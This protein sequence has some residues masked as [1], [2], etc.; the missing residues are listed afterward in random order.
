MTD[1]KA[2]LD[3]ANTEIIKVA[4]IL[5]TG[6]YNVSEDKDD[7]SVKVPAS[8]LHLIGKQNERMKTLATRLKNASDVI[9]KALTT[10]PAPTVMG[11]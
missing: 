1:N 5:A 6:Q 9:R 4:A 2:A 8:V 7:Y 11:G 3:A 10:P